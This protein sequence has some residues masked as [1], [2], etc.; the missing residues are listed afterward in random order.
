MVHPL[1]E[2]RSL[3]IALV[4]ETFPPE[5]NGVAMTLGRLVDGLAGRGHRVQVVRCRRPGETPPIPRDRIEHLALP[6]L[7][8]P[9][10]QGLRLGLPAGG[11]LREAWTREPPD[12]VHVATEG[13]LGRSAQRTALDLGIAHSSSFHTNFDDYAKHYRIGLL[14][15]LVKRSLRN[16]H[17]RA[18]VTMAPS[19]DLI[20]RLTTEGYANLAL[21]GRGVDTALFDPA[22]RDH[23][24]RRSWGAGATDPVLI[25]VGRV[26]PEKNIPLAL[27]AFARIRELIPGARMVV[28]GDGPL[29]GSLAARQPEVH[30][31]GALPVDELARHY[32]SADVFLFPS[33]SETFGNVLLEACAS[34]LATVSFDYAAPKAYIRHGANGLLADFGDEDG[35]LDLAV[36]LV[37]DPLRIGRLRH[38]A[39]ATAETIG[40]DAVI[41]RFEGYLRQAADG[42]FTGASPRLHVKTV[43]DVRTP[44]GR[45][46]CAPSTT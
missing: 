25:H 9:R 27:E 23:G 40:W 41:D 16:F 39:R 26:A 18:R 13:P 17:G 15:G 38:A 8:I 10:Y 20:D 32:A 46:P 45:Q 24:L 29:R 14:R 44:G 42:I 12:I 43:G 3:R 22:K 37:A 36:S 11:R 31:T 1:P 6:S 35:W 30:F 33:M 2:F 4:S 7:P 19:Q 28:V 34:G 21:L 5:I